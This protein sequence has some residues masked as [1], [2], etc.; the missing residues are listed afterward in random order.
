MFVTHNYSGAQTW[1]CKIIWTSFLVLLQNGHS[2]HQRAERAALAKGRCY[3]WGSYLGP[4]ALKVKGVW[5]LMLTSVS[6]M[7]CTGMIRLPKSFVKCNWGKKKTK[8]VLVHFGME[9]FHWKISREFLKAKAAWKTLLQYQR[10]RAC[11]S[12]E[13]ILSKILQFC[14]VTAISQSGSSLQNS[15][16]T[17]TTVNS[18]K[19]STKRYSKIP[20]YCYTCY[21]VSSYSHLQVYSLPH[22]IFYCVW[23]FSEELVAM[24]MHSLETQPNTGRLMWETQENSVYRPRKK[25]KTKR[26][27]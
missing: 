6:Q 13:L 15:V 22:F 10:E 16:Y 1:N 21:T 5:F 4:N 17:Q 14:F 26:M 8:P 25:K 19:L 7:R 23:N 27:A 20:I 9:Y 18:Q 12:K 24:A 3:S 11:T 2:L